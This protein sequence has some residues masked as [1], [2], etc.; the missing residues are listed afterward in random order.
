MISH[1]SHSGIRSKADVTSLP[2]S[3]ATGKSQFYEY[4]ELTKPRLS[5]LSVITA[6]VGY[7]AANPQR[8]LSTLIALLLGTSF[9][10]GSAGALNQWMERDIDR[11]MVRT[12]SRPI[13]SGN[14]SP[15]NALIFGLV[16]G[17]IGVGLVWFGTNPLATLLT[18]ATLVS[19]LAVYTPLKQ[20]THWCTFFGSIPGAIPPL[21]GWAAASGTIELLGW[22]LFGILFCWQ[23]PHFMAIAWT[24]KKD[25]ADGGFVMSTVV[26]PTGKKAAHQSI[27]YTVLLLSISLIPWF[28]GETTFIV[29]ELTALLA[30][31]WF[32]L[33]AY[34]FWRSAKKDQPARKMFFAS[35]FYLPLILA[36]LVI[37]RWLFV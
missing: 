22:V 23:I 35:I 4:W 19:Y 8:D 21:I 20:K 11:R 17:I 32:M 14:V 25:Y 33:K 30:G 2:E 1:P 9:A 26:D 24:Y 34:F 7:L 31:V 37:D 16:L 18:I 3:M 10:A 36:A 29:Y 15:L 6:V 28:A 12:Q 5:L 27:L 13:P